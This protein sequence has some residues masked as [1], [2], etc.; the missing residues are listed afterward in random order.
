MPIHPAPPTDLA[1]VVKAFAQTAQAV[2]DLGSSCTP[3]DFELPTEC[4]GWT[5]RDQFSHIVGLESYLEGAKPPDVN[6]S[7]LAHVR[8]E[9]SRWIETWIQAR[10]DMPGADVVGELASLLPRRLSHL[11]DPALQAETV[12][13]NPLGPRAALA[14]VSIRTIDVWC[15]EQDL[16]VALGRPGNLDSPAAA[17][18]VQSVLD[19]LPVIVA[20]RAAVPVGDVVIIDST[21]PVAARGGV[22][23][24]EGRDGR[25]LGEALFTGG[26]SGQDPAMPQG[27]RTTIT[28]STEALT[29]RAAGR[30]AVDDLH[31]TVI[32]DADLARAVLERLPVTP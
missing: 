24:V 14:A 8:D 29:R 9:R 3:A 30:R 31:Y 6:V 20:R 23:V 2:L 15:H 7:G 28:L 21:G 26:P 27:P 19:A 13:D 11:R 12:I 32:G 25:A 4:P 1:G 18:F 5:V 16:R 22:R 10:R 17:V